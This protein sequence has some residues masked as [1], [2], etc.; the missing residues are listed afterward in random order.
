[1][2]GVE[3]ETNYFSIEFLDDYYSE[4]EE[5]LVIVRRAL[6]G[7]EEFLTR[8]QSGPSLLP[9]LL[10]ELFRSFHSLKGI[11]GMVGLRE[12]EQLAHEMESYLRALRQSQ[13]ALTEEGIEGLVA[14]TKALELVI[15]RRRSE[16]P[17]PE[18]G[19]VLRRLWALI[20]GAGCETPSRSAFSS[21]NPSESSALP[22]VMPELNLEARTRLA[23]ALR[24][25]ARAW[26][27]HFAHSAELANRGVNVNAVRA[28]LQE[29]G[30]LIQAI[31]LVT[32][33]AGIAFEFIIATGSDEAL[34]AICG[35][36]GLS[37]VP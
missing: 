26:K 22:S 7:L 8:G 1:M 23:A 24:G 32:A 18:I 6:L 2:S 29:V 37:C 35:K 15:A 4:C 30:E 34:L 11:S 27:V 19:P 17:L 12:A 28:R 10:E 3:S 25:D 20:P 33:G 13:V 14:G 5:H 21:E 31:P 36:D 16:Q 9:L